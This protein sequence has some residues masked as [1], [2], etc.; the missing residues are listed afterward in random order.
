M[1]EIA[2]DDPQ[3]FIDAYPVLCAVA[4]RVQL[5]GQTMTAALTGTLRR[6]GHLLKPEDTPSHE[7]ETGMIGELRLLAGLVRTTGPTAALQAWRGGQ[8]EEHDFGLP[9]HDVE[10]KTTTSE[11]R[12]HW[13]A[14][15][16]QL[17]PT[18]DRPL[19]L[20]SMQITRAGLDGVTL[21]DLVIRVRDL[22][23]AG[24]AETLDQRL[25]AAGWRDSYATHCHQRWRMRTPPAVFAATDGFPRLTPD[26]LTHAGAGTTEITDVQYRIDVTA[27][28]PDTGPPLVAAMLAAG[29]QELP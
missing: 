22:Y 8:P 6:L 11:H 4:D 17:V 16:T 24:D 15:L 27:R 28:K 23:T 19:W 26:V 29:Q 3:I 14:S 21:S 12:V 7:F 10:V 1:I 25:H 18:G 5:D 2:V 20:V 13:I 9:G